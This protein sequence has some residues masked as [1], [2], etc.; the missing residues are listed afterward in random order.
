LD[1]EK[2][3]VHELARKLAPH[4][5][6][7]KIG[8]GLFMEGGPALVE[9]IKALGRKIFLDVKLYD[10]PETVARA[11][12]QAVR[13]GVDFMTVHASGG[14]RMLAAAREAGAGVRLLGVTVLTSFDEAQ[15]AAEWDLKESVPERVSRWARLA[16]DA[17]LAG[18]V[19]SPLELAAV[20]EALKPGMITVVPGIR[21]AKDAPGD[22]RRTMSAHDAVKAGADLLVVGRPIIASPDPVAAA[23]RI[24]DEIEKALG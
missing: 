12:R 14:S 7:F 8:P 11:C 21:S 9:E 22:Q 20:K 1:V 6:V 18:I 23:I 2:A 17:G 15:L 16:S 5:G 4:V 10:I 24:G 13:L 3:A 19:C